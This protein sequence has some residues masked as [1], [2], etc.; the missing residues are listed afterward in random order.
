MLQVQ[1]TIYKNAEETSLYF[2]III[3][4]FSSW[5]VSLLACDGVLLWSAEA[6]MCVL[7]VMA[8][9]ISLWLHTFMFIGLIAFIFFIN[10]W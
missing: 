10:F 4:Y 1:G 7:T 8:D 3:Y 2:W 9:Y 5:T 6:E